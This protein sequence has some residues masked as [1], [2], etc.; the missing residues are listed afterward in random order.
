MTRRVK[1]H[2]GRRVR[3]PPE[4]P[5]PAAARGPEQGPGGVPGGDPFPHLPPLPG[6]GTC[7]HRED[8]GTHAP[9]PEPGERAVRGPLH[10]PGPA[11]LQRDPAGRPGGGAGGQ[12]R[13]R[14][15]RLQLHVCPLQ[16]DIVER[17]ITRYS[18]PG[19]I[20]FDPFAGLFTVPYMAVKMGR[21]GLGTELNPDYFRDGVEYLREAE[22]EQDAPTLFDLV[23]GDAS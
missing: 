21:Y 13:K 12:G 19:E 14:S 4:G 3:P 6:A 23:G 1:P 10:G 20:V 15:K 5:P 8:P 7:L 17:V 22:L 16:L 18:N 9:H 2:L 11:G